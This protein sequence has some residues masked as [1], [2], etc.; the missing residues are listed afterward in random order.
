MPLF[1]PKHVASGNTISILDIIHKLFPKSELKNAQHINEEYKALADYPQV[2]AMQNLNISEFW[3]NISKIKNELD[4][5][6]FSNIFRI[7]EGILSL[8]HSSACV[9]R[10]FSIQNLIKTKLRN[11][12]ALPTCSALIQTR[13]LMKST[14]MCCYNYNAKNLTKYSLRKNVPEN[15][16]I[17]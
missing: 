15:E 9:E 4:E 14:D 3:W 17:D 7:V 5:L 13:D 16:L 6:M 2:K 1:E 12:L 10:I 8:P 11:R